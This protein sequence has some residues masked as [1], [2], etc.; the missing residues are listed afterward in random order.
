MHPRQ[1]RGL[2]G[3]INTLI[4]RAILN[5]V[6]SAPG[7]QNLQ[8]E[9]LADEV[10][11]GVEHVEPYGFTS[12]PLEG[13]EGVVLNVAG[14]RGACVAI[15]FHNRQFRLKD[16]GAGEVALYTHEGDKLV[17]S[18]DNHVTLTTKHFTVLAEEDVLIE[19]KVATLHAS[20][21]LTLETKHMHWKMD[22]VTWEGYT[23]GVTPELA[24]K[25]NINQDGWHHSTGDQVAGSVSQIH[26]LHQNAGGSGLSGEPQK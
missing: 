16:L 4:S 21:R 20:E 19:T 9:A 26:H 13:A 8:V 23:E 15:N 18:K 3:R 6:D 7:V 22:G 11:D 2:M 10:M 25:G 5:R 14:Q 17:F 1:L 12:V 24:M